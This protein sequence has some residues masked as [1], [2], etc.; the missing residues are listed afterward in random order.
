MDADIRHLRHFVAVAEEG[1]FGRAARGLGMAQPPLSQSIR[2]LEDGLGCPLFVRTSRSV[3]LTEAGRELLPLAQR[4]IHQH[5]VALNRV[6]DV[7]RGHVGRL[8]VG[9]LMSTLAPVVSG[10]LRR[11]AEAHPGVAIELEELTTVDQMQAL[12]SGRLDIGF[13][14]PPLLGPHRLRLTVIDR[15]HSVIALPADHPAAGEEA[16][17]LAAL[18]DDGF[19]CPPA[20]RGPGYFGNLQQVFEA[21]GIQP[22]IVLTVT[23]PTTMILAVASGL[24]VALLSTPMAAVQVPGVVFRPLRPPA[25][26]P[27]HE[28]AV[29]HEPVLSRHRADVQRFLEVVDGV[30]KD[31]FADRRDRQG[32]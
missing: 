30:L 27:V 12:D 20:E 23:Q 16:V 19:I 15:D 28:L 9:V 4:L 5:A 11:F 22:R 25:D 14:R 32:D 6:R 21:A 3:E 17:D 10:L 1:G 8:R 13:L 18:R 24:G 29:A 26:R 2:R 31:G 7:A